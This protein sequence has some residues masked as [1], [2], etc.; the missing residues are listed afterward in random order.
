MSDVYDPIDGRMA[1]PRR[2][3]WP[4][5]LVLA[6][7]FF[8]IGIAAMGWVLSRWDAAARF[9]GVAPEPPA[10]AQVAPR[11]PPTTVQ[12]PS[13]PAQVVRPPADTPALPGAEPQRIVIDPEIT[14]RV[15][16]IESRLGQVDTQARAAVGNADR[17][18]GLLVA[19]A[20][21]RALDRGVSLGFLEALL[22]Q[23][24]GATQPQAV[25]TI[26]AAAREPVTLQELQDDLAQIGPQ[27]AGAGPQQGWWD[28]IRAE[29]GSL[30]IVRR[31]GTPSPVPAE[32]L[33]RATRRLEAGQVDV[34]LAEV[35]R[36]PGRDAAR[37]WVADARRY[38]LAR[39]ALDA[40]ETAAL[41]EPRMPPPQAS[42]SGP[43]LA[44][45]P[46]PAR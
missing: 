25:G 19:F 3:G 15:A 41:L 1:E 11:P 35:Q 20:A 14:R 42:G 36:L 37:E 5:Y 16:A 13:G 7:L 34:A 10:V 23:R 30:I 38:V 22:R 29:L 40:I 26:I 39:R 17:A 21:R 2:R 24:F 33:R 43:A 4:T 44:P 32:R 46:Q 8:V 28:A 27:L 45:T 9:I 18:E 31:E 12:T 6:L